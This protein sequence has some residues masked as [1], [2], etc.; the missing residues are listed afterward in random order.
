[1]K[2][3]T[4]TVKL[5][6]YIMV[7][8]LLWLH[9]HYRVDLLEVFTMTNTTS[10]QQHTARTGSEGNANTCSGTRRQGCVVSFLDRMHVMCTHVGETS[11]H[12]QDYADHIHMYGK[13]VYI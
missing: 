8:D 4:C 10:Q 5:C 7:L 2:T 9:V 13:L 6:T 12:R 1:M 3:C 11:G